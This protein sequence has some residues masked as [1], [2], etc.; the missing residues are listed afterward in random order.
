MCEINDTFALHNFIQAHKGFFLQVFCKD[1]RY[2]WSGAR[3]LSYYWKL[4]D[5]MFMWERKPLTPII[6]M[7]S[8]ESWHVGMLLC[9]KVFTVFIVSCH[10]SSFSWSQNHIIFIFLCRASINCLLTI[11][12][13]KNRNCFLLNSLLSF[14]CLYKTKWLTDKLQQVIKYIEW[15][16]V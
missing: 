16:N 10:F 7:K 15:T 2:Y 9:L 13:Q 1:N 5:S 8:P 3:H 12:S 11:V 6:R 4:I 14:L